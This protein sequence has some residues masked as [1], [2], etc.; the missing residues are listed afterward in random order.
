MTIA[1]IIARIT[2]ECPEFAEVGH[3]LTSPAI[4]AYPAALV[5]P[6]RNQA[7]PPFILAPG[8]YHQNV[9]AIFGVYILLERRQNGASD[10]GAADDFDALTASLR[11][12]L[13][14]WEANDGRMVRLQL[15]ELMG[16]NATVT[17]HAGAGLFTWR[18]N[19]S[20]AFEIRLTT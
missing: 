20:A 8:A 7:S 9:V 1:E 17:V 6:V 3:A 18:E 15:V 11:A 10:Q 4:L 13:T 12:A 14:N 2:A 5:T 19:F 16:F